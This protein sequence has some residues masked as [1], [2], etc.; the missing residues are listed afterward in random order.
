MCKQVKRMTIQISKTNKFD[1]WDRYLDPVSLYILIPWTLQCTMQKCRFFLTIFLLTSAT[2]RCWNECTGEVTLQPDPSESER[3]SKSKLWGEKYNLNSS[4]LAIN[5]Q[6]ITYPS[7]GD[8]FKY[9]VESQNIIYITVHKKSLN[10]STTFWGKKTP[11]TQNSKNHWI[12]HISLLLCWII[13]NLRV[14]IITDPCKFIPKGSTIYCSLCRNPF[15]SEELI[16][17]WIQIQLLPSHTNYIKQCSS[18]FTAECLELPY[19]QVLCSQ[20]PCHIIIADYILGIFRLPF[21]VSVLFTI[22][23]TAGTG[24]YLITIKICVLP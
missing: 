17:P 3:I 2:R 16:P 6:I 23:T 15:A 11:N 20:L 12:L 14:G 8:T 22:M 1:S 10:P 9:Y 21:S 4:L 19:P 5:F 18:S 24:I 7:L 13:L